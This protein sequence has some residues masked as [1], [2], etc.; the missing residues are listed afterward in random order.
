MKVGS[1]FLTFPADCKMVFRNFC[2]YFVISY[3][4]R[5]TKE[6]GI[7]FQALRT[8]MYY[9]V[10]NFRDAFVFMIPL[11][12]LIDDMFPENKGRHLVPPYKF[13]VLAETHLS[14]LE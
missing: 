4:N 11:F 14:N 10:L 8:L 2:G 9:Y 3:L 1:I 7:F 13:V 12:V 5:K 6:G